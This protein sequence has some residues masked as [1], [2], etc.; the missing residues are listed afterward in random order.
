M[1]GAR[2]PRGR[3]MSLGSEMLKPRACLPGLGQE[4]ADKGLLSKQRNSRNRQV[5]MV[6]LVFLI[7][8]IPWSFPVVLMWKCL[9]WL[10]IWV[11]KSTMCRRH[12]AVNFQMLTYRQTL[13]WL[14]RLRKG[15]SCTAV[16]S[17]KYL[18]CL[19][20]PGSR[21]LWTKQGTNQEEISQ[22]G[23]CSSASL[24]PYL[25]VVGW[26]HARDWIAST[27]TCGLR[28][29]C[30]RASYRKH[31]RS[32]EQWNPVTEQGRKLW[33][34]PGVLGSPPA[35]RAGVPIA[36]RLPQPQAAE[37]GTSP[38]ASQW[39]T[40]WEE[41]LTSGS[42]PAAVSRDTERNTPTQEKR[43]IICWL[44]NTAEAK[45]LQLIRLSIDVSH[46]L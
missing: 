24:W 12:P 45:D 3:E 6:D 25:C 17:G 29:A 36:L 34:T 39:F 20:M 8:A 43:A 9:R 37:W 18:L 14:G 44:M 27:R 28:Q 40:L 11:T 46:C 5:F 1:V 33:L 10:R 23:L 2:C 4:R 7:S 19:S 32:R 16:T 38:C 35:G 15:W 26:T 22:P 42:S 41:P 21:G 30:F 31:L 13:V